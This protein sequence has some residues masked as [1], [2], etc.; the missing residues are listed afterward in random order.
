MVV[1]AKLWLIDMKSVIS[2]MSLKWRMAALWG[3]VATCK[4]AII[5]FALVIGDPLVFKKP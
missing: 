5:C 3:K 2:L 4:R 1:S